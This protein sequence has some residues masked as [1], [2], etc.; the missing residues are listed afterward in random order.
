MQTVF[1]GAWLVENALKR[2][3]PIVFTEFAECDYINV[4]VNSGVAKE[5]II[6]TNECKIACQEIYHKTGIHA[7]PLDL[8]DS[9]HMFH[10]VS[11]LWMNT[12]ILDEN[13]F[14]LA[15]KCIASDGSIGITFNNKNVDY[16]VATTLFEDYGLKLDSMDSFTNHSTFIRGTKPHMPRMIIKVP[17]LQNDTKSDK[18]V[19]KKRTYEESVKTDSE[20]WKNPRALIG[21]YIR[22]MSTNEILHVEQID[23][24]YEHESDCH[25]NLRR[26]DGSLMREQIYHYSH[27]RGRGSPFRMATNEEVE[28]YKTYCTEVN[29]QEARERRPVN[30]Y[31]PEDGALTQDDIDYIFVQTS[32]YNNLPLQFKYLYFWNAE[33]TK[34]F[35]V[36]GII[37]GGFELSRVN[38]KDFKTKTVQKHV[39]MTNDCKIK[40]YEI[41]LHPHV[42]Y[43]LLKLTGDAIKV[44]CANYDNI[45]EVKRDYL[46][47]R[48]P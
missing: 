26:I 3:G 46:A 6:V 11:L 33:F 38:L 2:S 18:M 4:L 14:R 35:T 27:P 48:T 8:N 9:F 32:E 25:Y 47:K 1:Y 22:M 16:C 19:S 20:P 13:V 42:V 37:N 29:A 17:I 45:D 43:D 10:N 31:V 28:H 7:W 12:T 21:H 24:L 15:I 34:L 44:Y 30:K 23:G 40:K 41:G 39:L 5:R 36:S